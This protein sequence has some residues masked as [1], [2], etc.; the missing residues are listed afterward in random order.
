MPLTGMIRWGY[1]PESMIRWGYSPN[2]MI[3]WGYAPN[4]RIRWGYAPN[5]AELPLT[6]VIRWG[7]APNS[8]IRWGYAPNSM[9]QVGI[10]QP[11]SLNPSRRM[12]PAAAGRGRNDRMNPA[13]QKA[14]EPASRGP[15]E[16]TGF[17]DPGAVG[18]AAQ[19]AELLLCAL[20]RR[21]PVRLYQLS[22]S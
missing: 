14:R 18:P 10:S 21:S 6:G 5:S 16:R 22:F 17:N 9:I 19:G 4:S 11:G 15:P 12:W 20:S 8:T 13:L 7:Y 2:S 3:R 1:A